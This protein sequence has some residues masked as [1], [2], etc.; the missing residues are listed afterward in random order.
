MV[1][2]SPVSCGASWWYEGTGHTL[3]EVIPMFPGS[4]IPCIH[5]TN[6]KNMTKGPVVPRSYVPQLWGRGLKLLT[7]L[8]EDG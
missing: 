5:M 6:S 1:M 2:C 3:D 8:Q 7:Q 4:Y